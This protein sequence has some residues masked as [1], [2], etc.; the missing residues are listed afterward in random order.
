MVNGK[1]MVF[2]MPSFFCFDFRNRNTLQTHQDAH[3]A[4]IKSK[5]VSNISPLT[6]N[7]ILGQNNRLLKFYKWAFSF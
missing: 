3:K 4:L 2:A 7:A 5:Q 1:G 6:Q